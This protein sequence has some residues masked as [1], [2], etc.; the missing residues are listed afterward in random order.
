[1]GVNF[2]PPQRD[3]S[4]VAKPPRIHPFCSPIR[5]VKSSFHRTPT[6]PV[7]VEAVIP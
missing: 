4:S 7:W 5:E 6:C 1:V 2:G 3:E